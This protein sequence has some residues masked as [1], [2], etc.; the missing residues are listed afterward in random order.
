MLSREM[1]YAKQWS[2][3]YTSVS[4]KILDLLVLEKLNLVMLIT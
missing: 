3:V 2:Y 4:R 1:Y